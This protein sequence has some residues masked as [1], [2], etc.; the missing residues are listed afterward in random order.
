MSSRSLVIA[1]LALIIFSAGCDSGNKAEDASPTPSP[2]P[3]IE[4]PRTLTANAE[5]RYQAEQGLVSGRIS[6]REAASQ[7]VKTEMPGWTLRGISAE[8]YDSN[9]YWVDVDIENGQRKMVVSLIAK[10][11]FLEGGKSYWKAFPLDKSHASQL[12]D[13]RDSETQRQLDVYKSGGKP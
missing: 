11:F 5:E 12:H 1:L 6:A 13:A 9:I 4:S 2:S 3:V 10:A 8:S 7:Y